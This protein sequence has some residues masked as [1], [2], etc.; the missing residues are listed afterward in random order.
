MNKFCE[1]WLFHIYSNI[2]VHNYANK[3]VQVIQYGN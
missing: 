1:L 2:Y 3:P